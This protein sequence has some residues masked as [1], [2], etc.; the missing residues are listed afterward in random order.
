RDVDA[1]I[2]QPRTAQ[3]GFSVTSTR[4]YIAMKTPR[5]PNG[6]RSSEAHRRPRQYQY[7]G[8]PRPTSTT[9]MSD[10]FGFS[11]AVFTTRTA[12]PRTK[13][14]GTNGYPHVRYGRGT[15][16]L[17]RRRRKIARPPSTPNV[18]DA[19]VTHV[20]NCSYVPVSVSTADQAHVITIATCGVRY[21]GWTAAA[22]L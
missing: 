2:T 21:F 16:G 3:R 14:A 11:I 7:A 1:P 18:T 13:S 8:N 19:N 9:P 4:L 12:R 15:S 10:S 17:S 20:N 22:A 5:K 6:R